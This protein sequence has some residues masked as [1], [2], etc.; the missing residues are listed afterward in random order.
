MKTECYACG[1]SDANEVYDDGH[2]YCF[3][4]GTWKPE[5]DEGAA[6]VDTQSR[7]KHTQTGDHFAE[8]D[9]LDG[10]YGELGDRGLREKSLRKFKYSFGVVNGRPVHLANYYDDAGRLV[11]QK[12]RGANKEF[13]VVGSLS[14]AGLFGEQL[15]E[16][17]GRRLVITEGELD[18]ISYGQ[19]TGLRRPVVSVPT[20]AKGAAK[21][22]KSSLE[23]VESFDEVFFMFDQ[24]Q[25]GR[26]A[27]RECAA[28]LRPGIARI[29]ELP[30][31][32]ASDMLQANRTK[33]LIDSLDEAKTYRPD[34][35]VE[36]TDIPLEVLRK[37][38]SPGYLTPFTGLNTY[39]RGLHPAKL[40]TLCAGSGIGK[41]TLA[42]ELGYHLTAQH[43][44]KVG[45]IMLEESLVISGQ[46]LVAIDRNV[47][48]GDLMLEP[49]LL[50]EEEWAESK[51]RVV[52]PNAFYD[53]W[54][55]S[56]VDN[57][58][59]K[60]RYF[61]VG[62]G[63]KFIVLDHISMVVSGMQTNDE[64]KT[65]DLLMT[66]LRQVCEQTGAGII[67]VV[68]LK[69][70]YGK[71]SFNEGGRVSLTDL[72]GSASIEQLSDFV[73][74]LERDQQS[75]DDDTLSTVRILKN[76]IFGRV[77][78]CG[79]ARYDYDTGRLHNVGEFDLDDKTPDVPKEEFKF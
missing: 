54:G 51:A 61:A 42:R 66:R 55:S 22:I 73:V 43:S 25:P 12:C 35:I 52:D 15:W 36:G 63:C 27:A 39:M 56:D 6:V 8:S 41:S 26:D 21:A 30:L 53:A 37:K 7:Y 74:A 70:N 64:R 69:R 24:D 33:E 68:H 47:P 44:V 11:A 59:S 38:V 29:V 32:D 58:I 45:W 17:G 9:F 5:A 2:T 50:S 79:Y 13:W 40:L 18:A 57:I 62:S 28:L 65:I 48:V 78:Q 72:R 49:D 4:C 19:A 75:E 34:G 20:G 77:G 16:R 76:R 10:D 3:S 60:C 14:Q 67:A 1:S 23:F 71:D 31:K 46:G